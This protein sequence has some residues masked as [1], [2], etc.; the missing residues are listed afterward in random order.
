[1]TCC[2]Q[3]CVQGRKCPNRQP[4][5]LAPLVNVLGLLVLVPL[6]MLA[7]WLRGKK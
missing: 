7:G 2:N 5:N 3:D 6:H 1:V 4:A